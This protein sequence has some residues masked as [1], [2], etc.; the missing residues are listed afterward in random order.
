MEDVGATLRD[1]AGGIHAAPEHLAQVEDRLAMLDRLK[2]KYG[3]TLQE[4]IQFGADVSRKLLEVENKEEILQGLR[5]GLAKAAEE[6]LT[7]ARTLSKKR[8]DAARKL[9][10]SVEAEINDLAMKSVFRIEITPSE[11]EGNWTDSGIDQVIYMIS[12]NPGEPLRRLEHIASGG[13]LSRV[14]LALKASVESGGDL[15]SPK[16][17]EKGD[18]RDSACRK[19]RDQ[20]GPQKTLVFDEIDTGIGGRAAEAVGKKLKSLSRSNQV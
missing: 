17:R 20:P 15:S 12:T 4:V 8:G 6:Y 1:Y 18:P 16:E 2:R 13:E 7:T 14:M 3:P 19:K 5:S 9:E 11:E 10:R